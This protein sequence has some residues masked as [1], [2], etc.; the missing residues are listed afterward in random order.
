M[1]T[2]PRIETRTPCMWGVCSNY[3]AIAML[4]LLSIWSPI[5]MGIFSP[6]QYWYFFRSVLNSM[7]YFANCPNNASLQKALE[8]YSDF[9]S[10]TVLGAE[11]SCH[12]PCQ[13][14]LVRPK[15]YFTKPFVPIGCLSPS[16]LPYSVTLRM[17]T[18]I[19]LTESTFSYPFMTFASELGGNT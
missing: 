8:A 17:P 4:L 16:P 2:P 5:C 3:R 6:L 12:N 18:T 9:L 19:L 14:S 11:E 15:T 13:F 1:V 7:D 10:T